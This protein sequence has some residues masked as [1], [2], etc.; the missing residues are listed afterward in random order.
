MSAT[1]RLLER[2]QTGWAPDANDIYI[3]QYDLLDWRMAH[4]NQCL[5]LHGQDI[6]GWTIYAVDVLWIDEHLDCAVT[7]GG[8]FWL[9]DDQESEKVRYLG[10]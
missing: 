6:E 3:A 10:G 7:P 8:F 2:L 9:Y 4:V 5:I 1:E